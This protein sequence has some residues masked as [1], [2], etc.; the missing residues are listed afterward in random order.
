MPLE[1]CSRQP[2][3]PCSAQPMSVGRRDFLA[4]GSATV[5]TLLLGQVFP[6]RVGA[7]DEQTVVRVASFPRVRVTDLDAIQPDKPLAFN[8]PHDALHCA[9]LLVQL[10]A[11]AGGG[12]GPGQNIV[13]FN[14]RCTHM[15]A[16]VSQGYVSEHQ[17]IGCSEHLTTFDLTRH[18][19]VVAGHATESL[20]QIVLEIEDGVVFATS[21]IG[22]IY[23][24]AANPHSS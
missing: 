21:L 19:M 20:P 11:K 15:G 17:V 18:G 9:S 10:R 5:S 14:T 24:Y 6:G 23:G 16:D 4:I 22:L 3:V 1:R 7:Q 12:I 8:F 2:D 13:A